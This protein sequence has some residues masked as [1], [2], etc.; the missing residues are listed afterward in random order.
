MLPLHNHQRA[1][2]ALIV[3][4]TTGLPACVWDTEGAQV[5]VM[6]QTSDALMAD[7]EAY[8]GLVVAKVDR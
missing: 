2:S 6:Y 4:L 3:C 5:A 8:S 7:A 1:I